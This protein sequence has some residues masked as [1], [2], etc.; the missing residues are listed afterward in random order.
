LWYEGNDAHVHSGDERLRLSHIRWVF[1]DLGNTLI[2][3]KRAIDDRIGQIRRVLFG[4]GKQVS[5][6]AV[7]EAF[8]QASAEFAPRLITRA[9]EKLLS[10]PANRALVLQ[11][12]RY[13]KD[14]EAPYPGARELLAQLAAQYRIGVIA[15]QSMGTEQRL[16]VYGLAPFL[17]LCLSSAEIGLAKPDPALF[18]LALERV[19]CKPCQAVMVGDRLDNDIRPAKLLGW[20][21][22][23]VLQGFARVQSARDEDEEPD[24]TVG[25]L[26][27]IRD[28]L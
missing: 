8:E 5:V 22:I 6:E 26:E 23:R 17:A 19:G 24:F 12:V 4:L 20:R 14:L 13:R 9:L 2:D 15:N 11:Q 10:D 18:R 21:T 27:R 1:F 3:E 7:E 25:H 16:Q 28:I